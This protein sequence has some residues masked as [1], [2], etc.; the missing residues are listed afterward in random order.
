MLVI[1][2]SVATST[3]GISEPG[4]GDQADERVVHSHQGGV[5]GEPKKLTL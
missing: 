4:G 3:K 5:T 2:A 1:F